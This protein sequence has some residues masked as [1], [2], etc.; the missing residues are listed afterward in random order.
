MDGSLQARASLRLA[1]D[2][3]HEAQEKHRSLLRERDMLLRR[4]QIAR[5]DAR[6]FMARPV[7]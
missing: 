1:L 5:D 3:L 6:R 4:A 7:A 2:Q